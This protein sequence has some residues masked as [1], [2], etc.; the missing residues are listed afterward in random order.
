MCKF[1]LSLYI[2]LPPIAMS[3]LA[4]LALSPR[5]HLALG[6]QREAVLAARVHR[7]LLDEHMTNALDQRRRVY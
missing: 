5:V 1:T 6:T 3:Q 2:G 7:D 4:I